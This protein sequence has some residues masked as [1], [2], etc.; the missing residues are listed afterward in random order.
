MTFPEMSLQAAAF[1]LLASA[2]SDRHFC[3]AQTP[4]LRLVLAQDVPA[5]N[6]LRRYAKGLRAFNKA[7]ESILLTS[8]RNAK[9]NKHQMPRCFQ[10]REAVEDS[11]PRGEP[12]MERPDILQKS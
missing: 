3:P 6:E 9:N 8:G 4:L 5:L 11:I 10:N 1:K 2:A 12:A 7:I